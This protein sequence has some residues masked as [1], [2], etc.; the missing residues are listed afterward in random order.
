MPPAAN[1][2]M[3]VTINDAQQYLT[4]AFIFIPTQTQTRVPLCVTS[5]E[6]KANA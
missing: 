4:V 6:G 3:M 5:G 1:S 2:E